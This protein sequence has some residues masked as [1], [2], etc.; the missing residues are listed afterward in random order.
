MV[1]L[2]IL[3]LIAVGLYGIYQTIDRTT[4]VHKDEEFDKNV[5]FPEIIPEVTIGNIKVESKAPEVTPETPKP[6][7]K[8]RVPKKE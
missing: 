1:Y 3:L 2:F 8:K 6:P 4:E 5:P 7:R